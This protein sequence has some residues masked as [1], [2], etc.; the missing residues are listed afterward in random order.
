MFPYIGH[1]FVAALLESPARRPDS[2]LMRHPSKRHDGMST[3]PSVLKEREE[4]AI[5]KPM[6]SHIGQ[7]ESDWTCECA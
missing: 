2:V 5:T 4:Q 1:E 7:M 3:R 6:K